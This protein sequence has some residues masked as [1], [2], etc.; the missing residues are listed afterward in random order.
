MPKR[1]E[2]IALFVVLIALAGNSS[3]AASMVTFDFDDIQSSSKKGPRASDI[4]AY[5]ENLLGADVTVSPNTV[6]GD[7][8]PSVRSL[9]VLGTLSD[10]LGASNSFLK[11][12]KGKG[13]SGIAFDFGDNPIHSF[14]VDYQLFK[15]AKSFAIMADGVKVSQQILSKAQRKSGIAGHQDAYYF[16]RPVQTLQFVGLN[17]KSFSIDNLI[18]NIP[19][20]SGTD[21]VSW[22]DSN[23]PITSNY[24]NSLAVVGIDATNNPDQLNGTA[25][26][27]EPVSVLLVAV[28]LIGIVAAK[29]RL[30]LPA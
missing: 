30:E 22:D 10:T 25:A 14:S 9:R 26:V 23:V 18:I 13:T 24:L 12:G 5:M 21:D 29:R 7:A 28:G 3:S 8:R 19:L 20:E 27:P 17:K 16:D 1:W 6:A 15:K 4:E 2:W 11:V